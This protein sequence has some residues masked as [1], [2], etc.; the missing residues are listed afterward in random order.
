MR[1]RH[2]RTLQ[3]RVGSTRA[4][5]SRP[6]APHRPTRGEQWPTPPGAGTPDVAPAPGHS[7]PGRRQR[8]AQDVRLPLQRNIAD[9]AHD[10]PQSP[11]EE[12]FQEIL[13]SQLKILAHIHDLQMRFDRLERSMGTRI[14]PPASPTPFEPPQPLNRDEPPFVP[15]GLYVTCKRCAYRWLPRHTRRPKACPSCNGPWWYPVLYRWVRRKIS[16]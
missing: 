2:F 3:R 15:E 10:D 8:S 7:L 14:S 6:P 1:C 12:L 9:M 11:T 13:Y 5:N 16:P 4:P